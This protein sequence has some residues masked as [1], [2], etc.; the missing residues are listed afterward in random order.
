MTGS[1]FLYFSHKTQKNDGNKHDMPH[2]LL[3]FGTL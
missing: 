2:L 3:D 1:L